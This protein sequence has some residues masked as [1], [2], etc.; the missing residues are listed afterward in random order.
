MEGLDLGQRLAAFLRLRNGLGFLE[1]L[2]AGA[3]RPGEPVL[4]EFRRLRLPPTG[5]DVFGGDGD[6]LE[7]GFR[8]GERRGGCAQGLETDLLQGVRE[9]PPLEL[10]A[11][12]SGAFAGLQ[13]VQGGFGAVD[14]DFVVDDRGVGLR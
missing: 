3:D 5:G 9:E 13:F 4:I 6:R 10:D 1:G 2:V 8:E 11:V 7:A 12:L 14:E